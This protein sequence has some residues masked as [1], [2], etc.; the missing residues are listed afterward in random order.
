MKEKKY[1]I[2]LNE[3][4]LRLIADCLEDCSLFMAGQT[5]LH[6]CISKLEH[7]QK[8]ADTLKMAYRD[9][10]PDLAAKYG[11]N[12]Y[13]PWNGGECPNEAQRKFIAESYY[14]YREIRHFDVMNR[15]VD[16][17]YSSPTLR[18]ADSGEPIEIKEL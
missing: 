4:Q 10:V 15:G 14:L 12:T 18:C 1:Q 7:R 16:N 2:T 13:Y 9:V 17:V 6:N 3:R 11:T 5:E 8:A